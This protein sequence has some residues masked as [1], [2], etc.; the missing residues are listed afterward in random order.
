MAH[1][2]AAPPT[3][4]SLRLFTHDI[5]SRR[6]CGK[7]RMARLGLTPISSVHSVVEVETQPA[8]CYPQ[9]G[10]AAACP[11]ARNAAPNPTHQPYRRPSALCGPRSAPQEETR[12]SA[13]PIRLQGW[14]ERAR[15]RRQR[16]R[17]AA[18]A[19]RGGKA[20]YCSPRHQRR[21]LPAPSL[22]S[23]PHRP[24]T[25]HSWT[26]HQSQDAHA[27]PRLPR[28]AFIKCPMCR[29][30]KQKP[31]RHSAHKGWCGQGRCY[32]VTGQAGCVHPSPRASP[33]LT[34]HA[35]TEQIEPCSRRPIAGIR[36]QTKTPPR[37]STTQ[38]H[39]RRAGH[40][41]KHR[42]DGHGG[43][44][45]LPAPGARAAAP[46]AR[47]QKS[48]FVCSAFGVPGVHGAHRSQPPRRHRRRRPHSSALVARRP[49]QPAAAWSGAGARPR[50][51][52]GD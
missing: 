42:S 7:V 44:A 45:P 17:R 34:R 36:L 20:Q 9:Y 19:V 8:T 24:H 27:A 5:Y 3:G 51:P 31:A 14:G 22:A 26:P 39:H 2:T 43:D 11:A 50:A 49:Q 29:G 28:V 18:Q 40:P 23:A 48:R 52:G 16:T 46:R 25:P 38:P 35:A 6:P 21:R 1:P 13:A 47:R 4:S 15:A 33:L 10:C 37:T 41:Q 12:L 32:Q 30:G